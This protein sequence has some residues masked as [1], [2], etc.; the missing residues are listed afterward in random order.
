MNSGANPLLTNRNWLE[1]L[2]DFLLGPAPRSVLSNLSARADSEDANMHLAAAGLGLHSAS[3]SNLGI[4][5]GR[6]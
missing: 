6:G 4:G 2:L 1:R 5:R 3:N